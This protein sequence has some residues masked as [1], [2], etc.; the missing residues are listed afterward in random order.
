MQELCKNNAE[1]V[2]FKDRYAPYHAGRFTTQLKYKFYATGS[3][4]VVPKLKSKDKSRSI[5][6]AVLSDSGEEIHIGNVTVLANQNVPRVGSIVEV[7]YLYAFPG[8]SLFQAVLGQLRDDLEP[9]D[10]KQ[11]QLKYKAGTVG[12]ED[13]A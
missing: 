1:G 8:G 7:R 2:V 5:G 13:D 10:C 4:L 6:L 3:F 11:S 9:S 12:E